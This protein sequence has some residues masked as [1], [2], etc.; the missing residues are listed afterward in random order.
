[1]TDEVLSLARNCRHYAMCKIDF[2]GTGVCASGIEKQYVSFYPQGRMDLYA[3]LAE[4]KV[5][6]T[7]KCVEIA[8]SCDLC[9]KCDF[10]CY[11]VNEMKPSIV[12]GALKTLVGDYLESG[13]I[14]KKSAEGPHLHELRAI[15]G[16]EWATSDRAIAI[17][18]S[19]DP[20]PVAMP[21]MPDYVV[22]PGTRDEIASLLKMFTREKLKWA[23]RGNGSS[24]MGFV[25]SEGVVVDLNR[26]KDIVFDEKNWNVKVGP[27]VAAF[28]LQREA[29]GRGYRVNVAE[30]SALVCA[31]LM[32]SGIFSTFSASYGTAGDNFIDAEF[33]GKD[34]SGFSLNDKNGPN[35]FAFS[36]SDQEIPGICT[37]VSVKLHPVTEDEAG[38]LV[39]FDSL[40]K[41]V[42]FSK[43]CAIRRIGLAI[44]ILGGEYISTFISPTKQLAEE[45]KAVFTDKLGIAFLVLMIGDKYTLQS[46][47]EMGLPVF[48]QRL[49]RILS[50]G[51]PSL[52]SAGWL[53]LLS[54]FPSEEPFSYLKMEGLA[55][56]AETALMPSPELL[57]QSVDPEFKNFFEKLY[58][59]PEMTDL[60]W[61]NMFRIVS[62]RMG[63]EKHVVALII[64]LPVDFGL[65]S[66]IDAAFR[67]IADKH[68]LK[69]EFG[70]ITPIDNGKRCIFEYDYFL[71]HTDPDEISRMQPAVMEAAGMIEGYSARTGTVRWIRYVLYQGFAR[72]EN[73]LYS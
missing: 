20:C 28:D 8:D 37:S 14:I 29:A 52:K 43:D 6:V 60:V 64:Y 46:I 71:D 23:V 68:H 59:R 12:M 63:R 55:D 17:T 36:R 33:V 39:P 73:L 66:E 70:F 56:L 40:E 51:L 65:I 10:Q 45:I 25:M 41:A 42:A 47:S 67:S 50:L 49:Y 24:V 22:M 35:L 13:G 26:M 69:N 72:M 9:G 15:V 3:A 44:G 62:S 21:R 32:C 19:H 16:E 61:L 2:L 48:D 7:E 54:S 31:N 1:M 34:G 18:Y 57:A 53:S 58:A 30:P 5:P 38:V 11:F 27:G 4:H